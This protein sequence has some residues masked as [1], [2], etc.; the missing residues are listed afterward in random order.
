MPARATDTLAVELAG[1]GKSGPGIPVSARKPL[2]NWRQR[3]LKTFA[4]TGTVVAACKAARIDRSTAYRDRSKN[5]RFAAQWAEAEEAG[6]ELLEGE[7]H[8]RAYKGFMKPVFQNGKQVGAIRQYSDLLLIMLLR[9]RRPNVY[10]ENS[11]VELTG[12]GGGPIATTQILDGLTD[13]ERAALRRAIEAQLVD[14]SVA[15]EEQP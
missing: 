2:R 8:R 15:L 7:A 10:R 3:F 13:H 4:E 6:T 12:A 5:P 11:R 9:A 1:T 14:E